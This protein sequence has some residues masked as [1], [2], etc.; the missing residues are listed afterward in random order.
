MAFSII[1][2]KDFLL[3]VYSVIEHNAHQAVNQNTEGSKIVSLRL[4]KYRLWFFQVFMYIFVK[5]IHGNSLRKCM[6]TLLHILQNHPLF[7]RRKST[8]TKKNRS[9]VQLGKRCQKLDII[10]ENKVFQISKLSK[11]VRNANYSPKLVLLL[12]YEIKENKSERFI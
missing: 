10:L 11:N 1:G 8:P 7:S 4:L 12:S 2:P 3:S 6:T 5:Y 9:C